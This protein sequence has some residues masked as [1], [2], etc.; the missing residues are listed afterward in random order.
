MALNFSYCFICVDI[1]TLN[2]I[3]ILI[4]NGFDNLAFWKFINKYNKGA[5]WSRQTFWAL[6][7]P[8]KSVSQEKHLPEHME[9]V[10]GICVFDGNTPAKKKKKKSKTLT[11]SDCNWFETNGEI[12]LKN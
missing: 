8:R 9:I 7:A 11:F 3:D 5:G 4:L 12:K 2:G 6:P 10:P 1:L